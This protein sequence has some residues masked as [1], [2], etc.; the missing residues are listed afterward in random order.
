LFDGVDV[1]RAVVA[2]CGCNDERSWRRY[3]SCE[4]VKE[5]CVVSGVRDSVF[6]V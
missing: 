5:V 2:R 3:G 6:E 1:G 4:V